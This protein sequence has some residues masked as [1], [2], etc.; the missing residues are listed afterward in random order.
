MQG[1]LEHHSIS[2]ARVSQMP[3]QSAASFQSS[4]HGI[5]VLTSDAPWI[6]AGLVVVV[7]ASQSVTQPA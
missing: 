6:R 1:S 7:R 3:G 4:I 5:D 2:T